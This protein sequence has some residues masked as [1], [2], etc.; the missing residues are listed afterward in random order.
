LQNLQAALAAGDPPDVAQIGYL[1]TDYVAAN[2][3]FV[4]IT[5]L[6]ERFGGESHLA[7]F[8]DNI[9]ELGRVG[10]V[11]MG[12]PYS[13]SNIIMY[14]N[15]DLMAEAG[16]DPETPPETWEEWREVAQAVRE[17]TGKPMYLQILDDNWSTEALIASNGGELLTCEG[18]YYR[19]GFSSPEAIEAV[20]MWADMVREGLMLNALWNQ[21]EQA[22]L[23]GETL[24][25]GTTIAKRA[26]LQESAPFELGGTRF[27]RFGDRPT[28]LPGGGNVL[29][30][31]AQ[32]E[33]RQEATWAF[34]EFLTSEQGFTTWTMGTGYVP[35][36]A[37]ITDDPEYLGAF[38]ADNPIQQIAVEQLDNTIS[39]TSF[40]GADGLAANQALFA[41]LQRALGGQASVEEALGS[42]AQEVDR[43][44]HNERCN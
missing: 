19:A 39:W 44:I 32:D 31:F 2:F 33:A 16:L 18:G 29:T 3:P 21:G 20:Q 30:V 38:V 25:F 27:P 15:K 17:T 4:P 13:L 34:I 24:T 5:E 35:L 26:A 10:G 22:F 37:E 9:L 28:R 6:A 41:A 14:Y 1:Y 12:M 40:P 43:L 36:L 23:A 8:P 11:M 7:R 42:A